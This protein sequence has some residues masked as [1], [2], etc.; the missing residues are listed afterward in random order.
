MVKILDYTMNP[1][2]KGVSSILFGSTS[3][4]EVKKEIKKLDLS[5]YPSPFNSYAGAEPIGKDLPRFERL[6]DRA[7]TSNSNSVV[8]YLND[9]LA[10]YYFNKPEHLE[11]LYIHPNKNIAALAVLTFHSLYNVNPIAS[12]EF[13]QLKSMLITKDNTIKANL[14]LKTCDPHNRYTINRYPIGEERDEHLK[15]VRDDIIKKRIS[16]LIP[17]Q[18]DCI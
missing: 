16:S 5:Y 2:I 14:T 8:K 7:V 10:N 12:P 4:S 17:F 1:I 6:L 3:N 13:N 18:G 11:S 9:V 15:K